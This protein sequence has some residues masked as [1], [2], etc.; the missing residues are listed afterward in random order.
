VN[1]LIVEGMVHG[2]LPITPEGVWRRL[3]R[4]VC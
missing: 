4:R 2:S 1:Q 3:A